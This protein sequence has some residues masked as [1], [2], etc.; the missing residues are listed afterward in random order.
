VSPQ[1]LPAPIASPSAWRGRDLV[2]TSRW[3][4]RLDDAQRD[5][6]VH[7]TRVAVAAG[8]TTADLARED[9]DL[10]SLECEL[11]GWSRR[12]E[13][14]EGFVLVR[15][16]PVDELGADSA[17]AYFGLGLHLGTPV[18][19][20]RDGARLCDVRDHGVAHAGPEVRRYMTREAQGFHT[21]GADVIGLLCL[22]RAKSGG[23]SRIV[24]SL[25]IYNEIGRRRPD[26]LP[27]LYEPVTFEGDFVFELPICTV[28][29]GRLRTFYIGWYIH[30]AQRRPEVPRLRRE[31]LEML[32]LIEEIGADPTFHLDMDFQVGDIQLL[33]NACILHARTEYE[34]FVE[35][36]LKRHLLRLWLSPHDFSSVEETLGAGIPAAKQKSNNR[37]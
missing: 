4:V 6:I 2:D 24:S 3:V 30:D 12:L 13:R 18:P 14:E 35:P 31:Q 15:G 1:I 37:G 33:N 21:D 5:A 26:L 9:F 10:P 29:S 16:F 23:L 28:T 8:K 17:L 22:R 32:A 34:D 19:Q 25:A 20:N 36:S 11:R 7:A 27:V